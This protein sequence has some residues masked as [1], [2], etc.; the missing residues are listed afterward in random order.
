MYSTPEAKERDQQAKH[1]RAERDRNSSSKRQRVNSLKEGQAQLPGLCK[2]HAEGLVQLWELIRSNRNE[3]FIN[4]EAKSR[5]S[6]CWV[7]RY[8]VAGRTGCRAACP[9]T[10]K[11]GYGH[12][13]LV[14]L[15]QATIQVTHLSLWNKQTVGGKRDETI[16]TRNDVAS[17]LCHNTLCFNPEHLIKERFV[18]NSSRNGC[19][20]SPCCHVPK[21]L[22]VHCPNPRR[23]GHS[24]KKKSR[25]T[26]PLTTNT[27]PLEVVCF[28]NPCASQSLVCAS[29]E[30]SS[31][32]KKRSFIEI[33][34]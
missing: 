26:K 19:K 1:A 32:K 22:A 33:S 5:R 14:G 31:K 16:C 15:H 21:C 2:I 11:Q 6:P 9:F 17:H 13:A 34:D 7:W 4:D 30:P 27:A 3:V 12:I 10:E 24:S 28:S 18:K 29:P 20:G 25:N 8:A 23:S